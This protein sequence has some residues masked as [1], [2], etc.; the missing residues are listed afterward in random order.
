M[1]T[2]AAQ[3]KATN[4][5]RKKIY[6]L[7]VSLPKDYQERIRKCA[8]KRGESVN[9]FVRSAIDDSLQKEED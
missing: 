2:T 7:Q 9:Q 6:S 1:S 5:Y 3:K 8:E 4:T